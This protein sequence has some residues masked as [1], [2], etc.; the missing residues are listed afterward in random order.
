MFRACTGSSPGSW[1]AWAST[2]HATRSSRLTAL[3]TISIPT[4][5][6][7]APGSPQATAPRRPWIGRSAHRLSEEW[8]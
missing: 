7:L 6:G 1:R 8:A 3:E 4:F 5:G 2:V